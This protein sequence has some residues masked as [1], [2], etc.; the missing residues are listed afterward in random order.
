MAFHNA[1]TLKKIKKG[2]S[3]VCFIVVGSYGR[4]RSTRIITNP[5]AMTA[6][7]MPIVAGTKYCSTTVCGLGVDGAGVVA[8]LLTAM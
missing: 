4:F 8:A 6:I 2:I 5:I 1:K 3:F 7:I